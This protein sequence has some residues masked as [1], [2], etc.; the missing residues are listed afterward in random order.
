MDKKKLQELANQIAVKREAIDAIF[1]AH[2]NNDMPEDVLKNLEGKVED[3]EKDEAEY[4]RMEKLVSTADANKA[5]LDQLNNTPAT[6]AILPQAQPTKS[7]RIVRY[8]SVKNF[9]G[10]TK[11]EAE[12]KAYRFGQWFLG[13]VMGYKKAA[14]WCSENN[15]EI[16]VHTEGVNEAGGFLV[17]E[18][19]DNDIIDLREQFGVFRR[20]ARIVPMINDTKTVPRRTGGLTA[21]FV[22]ENQA[23]TEST[24]GWDRVTLV[25]KKIA[26][27]SK[28]SSEVSEDAI[29]N[30]GDDMAGEI[31]YAFA[32]KEDECGFNGDGTSTFGGIQGVRTKILGLSATRANIAGLVVGAGNLW[33]ELTLADFEAV[34]GKLP[35]YADTPT[36]RWFV[37]K[38]FWATVMLRLMLAAGGTTAQEIVQGTRRPEFLG[39]GVEIAQVLP[40][41]EANDQ[42]CALLGDLRLAARFG[43]RR[44]TTIALS[45]HLNFAEDEIAIR[46]TERF[47]IVVHDVGN[48]SATASLREPGPIVGLLT[49]A[50]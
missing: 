49:A 24:K 45:E 7:I 50:A 5:R 18:E 27:L 2:P 15:I 6:Q 28:Y 14:Q 25:A 29:I 32:N 8:G 19:F 10:E 44:Q 9:Q 38:T 30:F 40:K 12:L 20:N 42:V 43:D 21:Y 13:S 48:A 23:P 26:V 17:P 4:K 11:T 31:A 36:A 47:D 16:K 39:Y 22:G 41:T 37:H 35:Q 46:G 34:V 3:V 33:S 1:K